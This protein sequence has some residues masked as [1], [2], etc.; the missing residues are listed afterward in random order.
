MI[1]TILNIRTEDSRASPSKQWFERQL[2]ELSSDEFVG[3][4][5]YTNVAQ[6][7]LPLL[8]ENGA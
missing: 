1:D 4:V 3:E 8:H 5:L 7:I 6:I 2:L